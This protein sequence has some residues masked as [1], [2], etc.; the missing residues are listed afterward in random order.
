MAVEV[1][2]NRFWGFGLRALSE[3]D[4]FLLLGAKR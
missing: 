1:G 3:N 4:S 2:K